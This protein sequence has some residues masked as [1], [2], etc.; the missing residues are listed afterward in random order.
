MDVRDNARLH[1]AALLNP[2]VQSERI[3]AF[4]EEFNWNDVI[5]I[6]KKLRPHNR[7]IRDGADNEPRDLTNVDVVR[8]RAERLLKSTFNVTGWTTLEQSLAGGIEGFE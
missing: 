4:A 3:F 8:S 2:A 5:G 6:L 7:L 1:V